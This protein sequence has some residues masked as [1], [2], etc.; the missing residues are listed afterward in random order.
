MVN[1]QKCLQAYCSP[2][3]LKERG[4]HY[5]GGTPLEGQSLEE[6]ELL[7]YEQINKLKTGSFD[8][9]LVK[10]IVLNQKVDKIRKYESYSGTA[11]SL[12]DA[13]VLG[14]NW[15]TEISELDAMLDYNKEDIMDFAKKF[16]T[17]GH[18]VI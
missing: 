9:Q 15:S 14:K 5:F 17:E 3:L 16:Y 7:F 1:A 2:S 11:Y 13:F 18:I 10:S 8:M 4:L 12:L 6:L